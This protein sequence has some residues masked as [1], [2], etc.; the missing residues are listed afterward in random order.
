MPGTCQLS[1]K[2]FFFA[3]LTPIMVL[4]LGV[5]DHRGKFPHSAPGKASHSYNDGFPA[6]SRNF[7]K[8]KNTQD[9]PRMV[10]VVWKLVAM[11]MI[12][13]KEK[14]MLT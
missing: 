7:K 9:S 10:R 14:L 6:L 1:V 12:G 3:H 13:G 11:F 4:G 8:P 2:D 5:A